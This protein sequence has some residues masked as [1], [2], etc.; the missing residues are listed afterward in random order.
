MPSGATGSPGVPGGRGVT[1]CLEGLLAALLLSV[2]LCYIP[3]LGPASRPPGPPCAVSST[4]PL[5]GPAHALP[6]AFWV[7]ARAACMRMRPACHPFAPLVL[8]LPLEPFGPGWIPPPGLILHVAVSAPLPLHTLWPACAPRRAV[9]RPLRERLAA[10]GNCGL[11]LWRRAV[12]RTRALEGVSES[13]AAAAWA[14]AVGGA[15]G[16]VALD[17]SD[18]LSELMC[19]TFCAACPHALLGGSCLCCLAVLF[20][21]DSS[22]VPCATRALGRPSS[23]CTHPSGGGCPLAFRPPNLWLGWLHLCVG[24]PALA[25][26]E[27]SLHFGPCLLV[28]LVF[29]GLA[30]PSTAKAV[31][32]PLVAS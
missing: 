30:L 8:L 26:R 19:R 13:G 14:V 20:S 1:G 24:S 2:R 22:L 27:P 4:F 10:S 7:C 32:L 31:A 3:P 6:Q 21:L 16:L 17:D 12:W 11:D 5:G 9:P 29:R 15:A 28:L 25:A 18:A 23:F